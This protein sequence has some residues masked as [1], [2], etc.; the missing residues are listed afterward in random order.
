MCVCVCV[1]LC[2][3]V[4][5]IRRLSDMDQD[6]ALSE[7]E[8]CIAM[9]LVLMRRKGTDIPSAL[10]HIL[11]NKDHTSEYLSLFMSRVSVCVCVC[12]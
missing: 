4:C 7:Q 9:K 3:C 5:D 6:N 12:V 1:C 2:D 10:P 11:L 8:F